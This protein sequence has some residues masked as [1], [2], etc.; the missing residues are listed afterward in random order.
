[1]DAQDHFQS[2]AENKENIKSLIKAQTLVSRVDELIKDPVQHI[3][4]QTRPDLNRLG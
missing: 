2:D 1:M 3:P 4:E